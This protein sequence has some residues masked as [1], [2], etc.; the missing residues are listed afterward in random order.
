MIDGIGSLRGLIL[1]WHA[2]VL[3]SPTALQTKAPCS[4]TSAQDLAA[5][6]CIQ[7]TPGAIA[8][9]PVAPKTPSAKRGHVLADK[10][11]RT[12]LARTK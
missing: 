12:I 6:Y 10:E 2:G 5:A 7:Q 1:V 9:N 4:S 3:R 11:T 8:D